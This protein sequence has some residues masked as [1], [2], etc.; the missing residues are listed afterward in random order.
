MVKNM[1]KM[2]IAM[3]VVGW[4]LTS[5]IAGVNAFQKIQLPEQSEELPGQSQPIKVKLFPDI[6]VDDDAEP[7]GDGSYEHPFQRIQDGIDA[8]SDGDTIFV[9]NGLYYEHII[10]NGKSINLIG[11]AAG[12]TIINGILESVA[13]NA[14][15]ISICA[16]S[17]YI[18]GFTIKMGA[19][20]GIY[21]DSSDNNTICGNIVSNND[22][23]IYLHFSDDNIISGNIITSNDQCGVRILSSDDNLFYNN[24]IAYNYHFG[25]QML[26]S[27]DN[28]LYHNNFIENGINAWDS[29]LCGGNMW[30]NG[31]PSG[32]NY[33][34]DYT[35]TDEDGDGIGD[36]S[37]H[38]YPEESEDNYP[39][40]N[41]DGWEE[42]DN[43]PTQ[44]STGSAIKG[45][46]SITYGAE[47]DR[48]D[49]LAISIP[50]N[51]FSINTLFMRLL[52]RYPHAL[53]IL[54]YL[55][56]V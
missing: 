52:Q 15:I 25:V 22:V 49:P 10:I 19:L 38:I 28:L 40:M 43:P 6:Y 24:N 21:V 18:S 27:D 54:R 5:S 55:L 9:F 29:C 36:T 14:P 44:S 33:W 16:D 30:D 32:G 41:P 53:Q 48:S 1:K 8:A 13:K 50:K 26:C 17:V 45:S 3:M 46:Q 51:S 23:G 7:G 11:E 35:G 34:D 42:Q 4:L 20:Y 37:Y 2:I 12:S 56:G 47:R 39:F 31:Y